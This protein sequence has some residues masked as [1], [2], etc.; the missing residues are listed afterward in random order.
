[1]IETQ[2][3]IL[4]RWREADRGP[5]AAM[6]ED[7]EVAYWLGGSEFASKVA[8]AT[9]R[10]DAGIEARGFG[11]FAIQRRDD[12]ALLGCTGVVPITSG[13]PVS[14]HEVEWR[15]ARWAWGCG[16][17]TESARAVM[18]DAFGRG[19]EEILSFTASTNLRSQ[20]VMKRLGMIREPARDFDHP[21]LEAGHPLRRHLVY[22]ARRSGT[23]G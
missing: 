11:L 19:L 10:Y 1:V 5:F 2:R 22:A 8:L 16:Y 15:L 20:A 17:A 6:H 14:G 13:L 7:P 12:G 3:L 21:E 4:R 23:G 9:D 18:D